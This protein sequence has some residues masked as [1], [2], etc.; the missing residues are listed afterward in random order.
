MYLCERCRLH[1]Q[2]VNFTFS[3]G[4]GG[5]PGFR[6]NAETQC[7]ALSS[8]RRCIIFLIISSELQLLVLSL[9]LY[10]SI[11]ILYIYIFRS[12][13][14]THTR[15]GSIPTST[16]CQ[17]YLPHTWI[18]SSE[19]GGVSKEQFEEFM[20]TAVLP[21]LTQTYNTKKGER[22]FLIII[23]FPKTHELSH[24]FLRK[25]NERGVHVCRLP[26]NSTSYSQVMD[27]RCMFGL[28]KRAYYKSK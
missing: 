26:A 15:I 10:L 19:Q 2:A 27:N 28:F 25:C 20:Q 3:F 5:V 23:D 16:D 17:D 1:Q 6:R 4:K 9:C 7:S 13:T 24:D 14:H 18:T 22:E 8:I 21:H 12:H 11:Y